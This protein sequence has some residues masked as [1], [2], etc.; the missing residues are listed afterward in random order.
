MLVTAI[1]HKLDNGFKARIVEASHPSTFVMGDHLH[2][3]N[4]KVIPANHYSLVTMNISAKGRRVVK[5]IIKTVDA[6]Q[7]HT[8]RPGSLVALAPAPTLTYVKSIFNPK[9]TLIGED[10]P[11]EIKTEAAEVI[12]HPAVTEEFYVGDEARLIFNTALRMSN[13]KPERAVKLMVVGPSGYGKT[14]LPKLFASLAGK[15]FM[16][17]NCG[18]IRDPEEWFGFR[19]AREGSTVFIRSQFIKIME[20]GN[21]VVVLDEFNRIEPWLHNTLFPLLDSDGATVVHD[22]HFAIGPGVIVAGT[23]NVGH[24]YTGVFELDQA[25]YNRFD[26]TVEVGPMPHNEEVNVLVKRTGL[27][28]TSA[29]EVVKM[30]N[31]L[32]QNKVVCSTRTTLLIAAMVSSGLYIREAFETA[33]VKR[34][35]TDEGE[36]GLRKTVIDL[37][38]A[39]FQPFTLRKLPGDIFGGTKAAATSEAKSSYAGHVVLAMENKNLG[40]VTIIQIL[41]ELDVV[42]SIVKDGTQMLSFKEAQGYVSL[43]QKGEKV[44]LPLTTMP[45]REKQKTMANKVKGAGATIDFALGEVQQ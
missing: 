16:R 29:S 4:F 7:R 35:P 1:I 23:I 3:R 10:K 22:E 2:N 43:L 32:R 8:L 6:S 44:T 14:E 41:R 9:I 15:K 33:V 37:I 20:E 19:E 12:D 24:Q 40:S 45:S 30:A 11:M 28:G 39:Q 42:P 26:F 34:V 25:L 21:V 31:I 27:T 38:N 5:K 36:G 13:A 17:M 18:T